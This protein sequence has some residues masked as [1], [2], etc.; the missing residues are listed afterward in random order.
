MTQDEFFE[1]WR[2]GEGLSAR[3]SGSTGKPKEVILPK[4]LIEASAKRTNSFFGIGPSSHL[5]VPL[6]FK[7]IAAKMMGVRATLAG[8][9]LTSE[10][11]SNRPLSNIGKEETIDLLAVV[12][13]QMEYIL[14]CLTD[15][16]STASGNFNG[17]SVERERRGMP[18]IKAIIIGGGIIPEKIKKRILNANLN[19]WETY[20]MTET[21]SHIALRRV[22]D[23][24]FTALNGITLSTDADNCLIIKMKGFPEVFT[25]DIAELKDSRTFR[26]LGRRDNIINTGGKK[27][28]AEELER[29]LEDVWEGQTFAVMSRP[30]D[31]W[32][33]RIVAVVEGEGDE[34]RLLDFARKKIKPYL[35]PK[36]IRFV[37]KL[38]RTENGK[39]RRGD[40]LKD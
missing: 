23:A 28:A 7:Y 38:P 1:S 30:D 40:L 18:Y 34:Q 19:A 39:I 33:E 6:D 12:P 20:G 31:K 3:T 4:E 22:G 17:K 29:M 2:P 37:K 24:W 16:D 8:A 27:I 15:T 35:I 25:N 10:S 9:R 14:D 32:G 21:A 26:I 13:S 11:P 5:H 36:E